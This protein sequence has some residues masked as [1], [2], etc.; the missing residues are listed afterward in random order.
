MTRSAASV[1]EDRLV[2]LRR[3]LLALLLLALVWAA[4]CGREVP[5]DET[6]SVPA[7]G[8]PT[9]AFGEPGDAGGTV[10]LA[11][12]AASVSLGRAAA[13][14]FAADDPDT[15]VEVEQRAPAAAVAALCAGQLEIAGTDRKL[16]EAERE[17]C[18]GT[19]DGAVELHLADAGA[20]PVYLVT[21]QKALFDKLEVESYLDFILT[22]A[23]DVAR[24]AGLRA[25]EPEQLDEAQSR[26]EQGLAGVG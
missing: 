4:G 13:R 20:R 16:T 18:R 25:L 8:D 19:Q 2:V 15:E 21:T 10:R 9:G 7:G 1:R 11:G 12:D 3:V 26:F 24:Q 23:P 14:G 22:N 5:A 17:R 6:E